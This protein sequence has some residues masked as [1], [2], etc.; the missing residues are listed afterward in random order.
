M[1]API[2]MKKRV[3]MYI[4]H[5][6]TMGYAKDS[7]KSSLLKF[8]DYADKK[9]HRGPLTIDLAMEWSRASKTNRRSAWARRLWLLYSFAKYY[10]AI[11]PETEIPPRNLYGSILYRPAPYIYTEREVSDLMQKTKLLRPVRG[12]KPITFK[13]LLGL[14]A[15]T[16]IRVSEAIELTEKDVDLANG[17]LT[18]RETKAHKSRC[19]PLHITS[20]RALKRYVVLRNKHIPSGA[21]DFFFL[22]DN[23]KPLNLIQT[24]K[25]YRWLR[26]KTGL[27][28][29][30]RL[31]DFRHTF[32]CR[33]LLKWYEEK[34][35]IDMMMVYLATYLGHV[36]VLSTYWYLTAT[37]AL[38][39]VASERFERFFNDSQGRQS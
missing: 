31:Y 25:D 37:P 21:S 6:Q 38:M 8:A 16:G 39:S 15:C 20:V 10:K 17:I 4:K 2:T 5:R 33:R 22:N 12:L 1:T 27:T 18:I 29:K 32:A 19:V 9:G 36:S 28:N 30:P 13:Y 35:D 26:E 34:K 3:E 14:F 24:E 23:G 7:T 11:E